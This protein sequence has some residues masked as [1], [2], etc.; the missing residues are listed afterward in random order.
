LKAQAYSKTCAEEPPPADP[1][2]DFGWEAGVADQ[3]R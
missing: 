2:L 1:L 3:G